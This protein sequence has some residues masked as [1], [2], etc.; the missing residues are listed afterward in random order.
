MVNPILLNKSSKNVSR[1]VGGVNISWNTSTTWWKK[2]KPELKLSSRKNTKSKS[3]SRKRTDRNF[4]KRRSLE[5][6]STKNFWTTTSINLKISRTKGEPIFSSD[7]MVRMT[8]SMPSSYWQRNV[9]RKE[10]QI[11]DHHSLFH[12][13]KG[14]LLTEHLRSKITNLR[15][16]MYLMVLTVYLRKTRLDLKYFRWTEIWSSLNYTPI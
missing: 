11:L 15:R 7:L 3:T 4:V 13:C 2:P 9:R 5:G 8:S 10:G 16:R 6:K 14:I 1:Y 12:K